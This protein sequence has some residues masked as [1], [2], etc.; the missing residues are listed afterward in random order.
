M[1]PWTFPATKIDI[2]AFG[3]TSAH[4][5]LLSSKP[6]SFVSGDIY[7]VVRLD[8]SHIGFYIADAVGHGMPAALMTMFIKN[9]LLTKRIVGH[10]YELVSPDVTLA[11]LNEDICGQDLSNCQF[12]SAV[13][14]VVDVNTLELTYAIGGH[15]RPIV[16]RAS[17]EMETLE[18]A[19]GDP[20]A[21]GPKVPAPS[22]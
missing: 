10:Q 19:G 13:Y 16:L 11:Q 8:E 20:V 12:C 2:F 3:A 14:A 5:T 1:V 22:L 7:D 9:S 6:A 21:Q 4:F 17:G 15:P 18:S